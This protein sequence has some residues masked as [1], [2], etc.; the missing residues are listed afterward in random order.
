MPEYVWQGD[1]RLFV[2]LFISVPFDRRRRRRYRSSGRD[3]GGRNRRS[4]RRRCCRRRRR[5]VCGLLAEDA[6][7]PWFSAA[8]SQNL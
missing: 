8:E 7:S 3:G 1:G 6:R 5:P 4:R 2:C